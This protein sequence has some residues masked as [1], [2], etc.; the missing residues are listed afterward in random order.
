MARILIV[1]DSLLC[2]SLLRDI[3]RDGGHEVLGEA[4]DGLEA[5]DLVRE[6]G[7]EL[8]TLDL[9]MPGR[10]GLATLQHLL[11][12]DPSLVVVVCSASLD[13]ER[14]IASMRGGALGCIVKPF[15][16]ETVLGAV[17]D[18]LARARAGDGVFASRSASTPSANCD[19]VIGERA[20]VRIDAALDFAWQAAG[21]LRFVETSTINLSDAE[22]RILSPFPPSG[23]LVGF[24]LELC[25]GGTPI[26]GRARM[27]S[28]HNDRATLVVQYVAP[29]D[30]KRLV[31]YIRDNQPA[32]RQD[33][34][35]GTSR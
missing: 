23:A 29:F 32:R 22:I 19:W 25:T 31:N 35:T 14:V 4:R 3:L 30:H 21:S 16:H 33:E 1:D 11:M 18:A 9:V 7:P 6:L 8:V 2:R 13:A 10:G 28:A 24:R 34:F 20:A 27:L 12:I 26:V 15:D 5:P 17:S